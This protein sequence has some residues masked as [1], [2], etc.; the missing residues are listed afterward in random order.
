MWRQSSDETRSCAV[1]AAAANLIVVA[2]PTPDEIYRL[3]QK[4]LR[5]QEGAAN[6]R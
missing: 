5:K 2:A 4:L 6:P 1:G 3:W